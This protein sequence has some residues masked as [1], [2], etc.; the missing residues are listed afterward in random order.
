MARTKTESLARRH[1][2][3]RRKV[4]G[5]PERPRLCIHKS[6][7]HL[8]AQI[9]DDTA[10]ASL[11]FATTNTKTLRA[12][13]K[14]HCNAAWAKRLGAEVAAKAK[15]RGIEAVV[16]DRGGYRYHGIIKAFGD[17]AREAGMKF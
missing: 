9:I 6:S 16:F 14:S 4:A 2:R 13:A 11:C 12:E 1:Q 10:G 3:V 8:Y 5:T 7:K 15:A 17:A